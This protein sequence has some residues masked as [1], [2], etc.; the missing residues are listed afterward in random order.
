[1]NK[2]EIAEKLKQEYLSKEFQ[3]LLSNSQHTKPGEYSLQ[4]PILSGIAYQCV[5]ED[6]LKDTNNLESFLSNKANNRDFSHHFY[7]RKEL[8]GEGENYMFRNHDKKY[9]KKISEEYYQQL[10]IIL[11]QYDSLKGI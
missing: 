4:G 5:F 7:E 11:E 3:Y 1:M 9:V 8:R 6:V 10:K 2:N